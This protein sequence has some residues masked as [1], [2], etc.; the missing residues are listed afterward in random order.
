MTTEH[1]WWQLNVVMTFNGPKQQT[2]LLTMIPSLSSWT[3]S[4]GLCTASISL[5]DTPLIDAN[6]HSWLCW[7][8]EIPET[9]SRH[10]MLRR[11][12]NKQ[13]KPRHF[14]VCDN[15]VVCICLDY[16]ILR[17]NLVHLLCSFGS[18]A[19][20]FAPFLDL[21]S[22]TICLWSVISLAIYFIL[23]KHHTTSHSV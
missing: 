21:C 1:Y 17:V 5:L 12:Q 13:H 19:G 14:V 9:R 10:R 22:R 2:Q 7:A 3:R 18:A 16:F 15:C 6:D 20:K 11:K 4:I 23:L 8:G